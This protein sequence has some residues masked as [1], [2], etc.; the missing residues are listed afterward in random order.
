MNTQRFGLRWQAERDTAFV[1]TTRVEIFTLLMRSKAPSMLR[2]AGAVHDAGG[3][4][5]GSLA[6]GR[7]FLASLLV[8]AIVI[9]SA[10]P[11]LAADDW[12]LPP[13]KTALK[14]GV[15]RE[16]VAGQCLLCHSTDYI[17]TQ[18]PL[19][20]AQWQATVEKMRAKYGAPLQTNMMPTLVEYLTAG[21]GKAS[22][23]K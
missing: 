12:K 15:G 1:R 23:P 3:I 9:L 13:E 5:S 16:L 4:H 21:Y 8:A 19:T 20:R 7:G 17:A 22:P 14:P 2:S 11:A 6:G 18:P 10:W